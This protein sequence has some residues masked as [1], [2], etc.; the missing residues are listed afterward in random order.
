M[1]PIK[2]TGNTYPEGQCTRYADEEYHSAT[3]YY[4]P[5]SANAKDWRIQAP[6]H[7]WTVSSRPVVPSIICLDAGVQLAHPVYGHVG[8]VTSIGKDLVQTTDLNWGPNPSHPVDVPFRTGQGVSFI[9]AA[10]SKGR[11]I[12]NTT[13]TVGQQLSDIVTNGKV[14]LAPGADVTDLLYALDRSM[15][16]TNPFIVT[17]A[18]DTIKIPGASVAGVQ[19]GGG[20]IEFT[21]PVAYIEGFGMN[22]FEDGIAL[23]WRGVF[24]VIGAFILIKV[25][26]NFI[27]FG[28]IAGAVKTGAALA[29][30]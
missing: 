3:G 27:D 19:V 10:D 15:D 18:T 4:V 30:L 9:Y 5:W 12:G 23:V 28:A 7:G 26:S 29:A 24:L 6:I 1:D 17:A 25:L 8:F 21:D 11:P 20:S 2:G 13:P 14:S 16:L 22:L